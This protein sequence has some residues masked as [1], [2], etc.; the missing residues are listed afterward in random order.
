M[1][2]LV[3]TR[4]GAQIR[5]AEG[6]VLVEQGGE[7]L[8]RL[9]QEQV[10]RV[11]ALGGVG[12]TTGFLNFA[13]AR[14]IPVTFLTQDGHYKGR[15]ESGGVRDV[16]L[17]LAQYDALNDLDF[18]REVAC[19][20][21]RAKVTAQRALLLRAGRNH[22]ADALT[23]A[24]SAMDALLERLADA[25]TLPQVMGVE[26][27]AARAYFG[28]LP[29]ALRR[30]LPFRGRSR[31]PPKDPVNALLSLGYG[32]LTAE[33]IGA[34]AGV[35]LDPQIGLFHSARGRMPALAQ[36]VVELFRAPVADALALSLVNLGVLKQED[37]ET[38]SN[39]GVLL[40]KSALETYFRHYRRRMQT[41]FRDRAGRPTSFRREVQAQAA[42]LRRVILREEEYQPFVAPVGGPLPG[43]MQTAP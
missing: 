10:E 11:L 43:K 2:T 17:R 20:L 21:V 23:E 14:R 24:A 8:S 3:V 22:P 38:A 34:L 31:R 25:R 39:G 19:R 9:P 27:S 36:D 13:L 4:Q 26:G 7:V 5:C 12:L 15:L 30:P 37:F 29:S 40:S 16:A 42:H 41:T 1:S 35:G 33:I 32:M 6:R 28:A 18:R